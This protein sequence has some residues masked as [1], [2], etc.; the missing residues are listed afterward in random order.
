MYRSD[1]CMAG[2]FRDIFLFRDYLR[3]R[4][5]L[6]LVAL[7]A[8]SIYLMRFFQVIS[9]YPPSFFG[10]P[11]AAS[12]VGGVLFGAG[13]VLGGGCLTTTL[14]RLGGGSMVSV[15]T[16]C[17]VLFGGL[18]SAALYPYIYSFAG[19]TVLFSNKTALEHIIGG[20]ADPVLAAFLLMIFLAWG[21]KGK[22]T[23]SQTGYAR[24]YLAPW[25]ASF[26]MAFVITA[27]L[28]LSGRPLAVNMGFEKLS[29]IL[30]ATL[31]PSVGE[32]IPYFHLY[33]P[34]LL[35]GGI[36][37]G[38]A[39]PAIDSIAI[40]QL[41]LMAG[42]AGGSFI[43]SLRLG[44]FRIKRLPPARQAF[45]AFTGGMLMAVGAFMAGGCNLWHIIGGLPVLALQ[46]IVFVFGVAGGSYLG[47]A[48]LKKQVL[49]GWR[50]GGLQWKTRL[51]TSSST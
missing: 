5:L 9:T 41:P 51:K 40:S 43:S 3:L 10:M 17:G 16:F 35:Y 26:M 33:S 27:L 48:F 24:G 6:L 15:I 8:F 46:S 32:K 1:F 4:A 36:M 49:E 2:A 37:D 14:Y 31:L 11:S 18:A 13:M 29:G 47:T 22:R 39:G 45:S 12:L 20:A 25:K 7:L 30:S 50:K 28:A 34:R 19:S 23:R 38:G 21:W 42:I 44:E